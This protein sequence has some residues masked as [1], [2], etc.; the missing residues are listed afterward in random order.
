[1]EEAFCAYCGVW[2]LTEEEHV[3]AQSFAPEELRANCRWVCV[4]ACPTCNRGFSADESD[5]GDFCVLAGSNGTTTLIRDALFY[6]PL[7]R[8]WQRS[9]GR[10]HGALRRTLASLQRPD[11][12]SPTSNEDLLGIPGEVRLVP[13]ERTFRV[14]RKIV[15]GLYYSHFTPVR[16]LPQVLPESQI[17]V[18]PIFDVTLDV[19]DD[20][21]DWHI[22]RDGVFRY[23]FVECGDEGLEFAGIDSIWLLDV[24]RGATFFVVVTSNTFPFVT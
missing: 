12:T 9:D 8:N 21:T 2:T 11:G 13:T 18:T 4:P 6:G 7:S 16:R 5:F 1:M 23:V 3:V 22:I 10:G 24:Y 17:H 20:F 14:V 19:I 15:R